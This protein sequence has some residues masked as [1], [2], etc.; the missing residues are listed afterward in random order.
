[1]VVLLLRIKEVTTFEDQ[2]PRL[3]ETLSR[4]LTAPLPSGPMPAALTTEPGMA[5][6]PMSKAPVPKTLTLLLIALDWPTVRVPAV[7]LMVPNHC[8]ASPTSLRKLVLAVFSK[9][10][11]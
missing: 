5:L 2:L 11:P 10:P 8:E 7:T 6:P 9:V 1:M 4:L 3:V